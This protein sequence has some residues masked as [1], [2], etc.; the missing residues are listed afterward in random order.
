MQAI[1]IQEHEE[2]VQFSAE[3]RFIYRQACH[4]HG[5]FDVEQAYDGANVNIREARLKRCAHFD[6]DRDAQDAG[7]AVHLLGRDKRARVQHLQ[8]QMEIEASRAAH[9]SIWDTA[10]HGLL[11]EKLRRPEAERC[12]QTVYGTSEHAWKS[13]DPKKKCF[14]M[15]IS[16]FD[17]DGL[18]RVRPEV[19]FKQPLRDTEV[20]PRLDFR[21]VVQHAVARMCNREAQQILSQTKLGLNSSLSV[22]F[23]SFKE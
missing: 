16:L 12:I 10:K 4:D 20:Y 5:I 2:F 9:L 1:R 7:E 17:R 14:E 22:P 8:D 21:H 23:D 13:K 11:A 18:P 6:L 19:H 15:K 3:E